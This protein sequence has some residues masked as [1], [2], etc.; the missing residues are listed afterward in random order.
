MSFKKEINMISHL[1]KKLQLRLTF[2][3]KTVLR[4]IKKFLFKKTCFA[5][6]A[7]PVTFCYIIYNANFL[8]LEYK[9]NFGKYHPVFPKNSKIEIFRTRRSKF[10][11]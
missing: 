8:L 10:D 5:K 4:K 6:I 3:S 11:S 9:N 1:A 2:K 7:G